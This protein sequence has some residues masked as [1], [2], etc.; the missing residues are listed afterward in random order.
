ML[1]LNFFFKKV[2]KNFYQ[3]KVLLEKL[4]AKFTSILYFKF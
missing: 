1:I 2:K 3:K 4:F